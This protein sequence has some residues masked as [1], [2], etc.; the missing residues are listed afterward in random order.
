M[1]ADGFSSGLPDEAI[2][3]F[4]KDGGQRLFT[5]MV[6]LNAVEGGG[7]TIFPRLGF[8]IPP[9]PGRLLLFAN[10]GAGDRD[11]TPLA[12]HAGETVT[13]GEKWVAVTWW[14]ERLPD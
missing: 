4:E 2:R 11:Q 12:A 3:R 7:D 13:A 1:H 5:T 14:R 6:Y 10:T 8:R 9:L